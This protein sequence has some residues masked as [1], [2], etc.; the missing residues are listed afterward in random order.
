M[1]GEKVDFVKFIVLKLDDLE[2][3]LS[4]EQVKQMIGIL[5]TVKEYRKRKGKNPDPHYYVVN[6][7]EPYAPKV[8]AIIDK[9]ESG[10]RV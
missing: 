5:D 9:Y 6:T 1:S 3:A 7:D 2:E 8:K 10:E 4:D